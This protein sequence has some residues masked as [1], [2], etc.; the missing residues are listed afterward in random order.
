[1][2]R[3]ANLIPLSHQHQHALALC[4]LVER[5]LAAGGKQPVCDEQARSVVN[6]FDAEMR[7]HFDIEEQVLFPALINFERVAD[8]VNELSDE[9]HR[10]RELVDRLRTGGDSPVLAEFTDLL[11]RHVRKEEN[12]LFQQAQELLG[13]EQLDGLGEQI[14]ARVA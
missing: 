3:D 1:M 9:H 5:A 13:R 8:L 10:M 7:T 11:R 6:H 4:V 12:V 14:A 2:L